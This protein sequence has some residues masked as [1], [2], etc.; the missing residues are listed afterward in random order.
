MADLPLAELAAAAL[1]GDLYR[2][3]DGWCPVDEPIGPVT[4]ALAIAGSIPSR[5][6]LERMT[7]AW[8]FG[9][10]VLPARHQVCVDIVDRVNLPPSAGYVLREVRGVASDTLPVGAILVTTPLRTVLDLCRDVSL[11]S[12]D[13]VPVIRHLLD[14]GRVD[15]TDAVRRLAGARQREC[16]RTRF[17]AASRRDRD[18]AWD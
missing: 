4:R 14:G 7:A 12:A 9:A 13:V 17:A 8:I 3:G 18:S 1:D 10:G 11:G 6:I 2:L 5:V 16:A 15:L